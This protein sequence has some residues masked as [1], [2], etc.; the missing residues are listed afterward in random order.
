RLNH[1][2]KRIEHSVKIR[3]RNIRSGIVNKI[4]GIVEKEGIRRVDSSATV[5]PAMMTITTTVASDDNS[6]TPS[7][8]YSGSSQ[9][10]DSPRISQLKASGRARAIG[11]GG[12]G[13]GGGG[14]AG[15]AG[16]GVGGGHGPQTLI[17]IE[18]ILRREDTL[19]DFVP[20]RQAMNS[21]ESDFDWDED[22]NIDDD[23]KNN[24]DNNNNNNNNNSAKE[25]KKKKKRSTWRQLAPFLRML[26]LIITVAPIVALPAVLTGIFLKTD[27]DPQNRDRQNLRRRVTK[28]AVVVI[29]GWLAFMWCII[30]INNWV[31]DLI[32]AAAVMVCSWIAPTK[33]ET[34]K[35]RLLIFVGT[36]KYIKWFID[37][38]WALAAFAVLSNMVYPLV[39]LQVWQALVIRILVSVLVLMG[40]VLLEKIILHKISKNF[41]QIAYADRIQENKY[42]LAVLDRLGTSRRKDKRA[43]GGGGGGGCDSAQSN[44]RSTPVPAFD[45]TEANTSKTP[46]MT[47]PT[48]PCT[49][50][51]MNGWDHVNLDSNGQST[52]DLLDDQ[53]VNGRGAGPPSTLD[54]RDQDRVHPQHNKSLHYAAKAEIMDE[55]SDGNSGDSGGEGGG[56]GDGE[57]PFHQFHRHHTQHLHVPL[58]TMTPHSTTVTQT[59]TSSYSRRKSQ[60]DILKG[61]NRKLHVLARADTNPSKDINSTENAK[62]LARSLFH[63]LQHSPLADQLTPPDFYP[64]F[65]TPEDAQKAFSLFDKDGNGDISKREMKEKIFYVYKERKDLHTAL[66]DL[67]Q[68]HPYDSG[69]L[70]DIDGN[71]MYVREVGLN[72]TMFVTWDGRRI[73]YPNN[74]LSQKAINNIRRS[75]NMTDKIVVHIDVYTSQEKI[76]DLRARMRDFLAK[77]SK[78]F[79]PDMEIQIQEIDVRLKISMCIEHKGNWQDSARRWARRTK[80]HYALKEAIEDLGIKYH[81]IP[82]RISLMQSEGGRDFH[83]LRSGPRRYCRGH[84]GHHDEAFRVSAAALAAARS[85]VRGQVISADSH[86]HHEV[87]ESSEPHKTLRFFNKEA[88]TRTKEIV[89]HV[90]TGFH[91]YIGITSVYPAGDDTKAQAEEERKAIIQKF[92]EELKASAL[93]NEKTRRFVVPIGFQ[94]A[95]SFLKALILKWEFQAVAKVRSYPKPRQANQAAAA[96]TLYM[97]KL[98][99]NRAVSDLDRGFYCALKHGYEIK[100]FIH[101]M[102]QLWLGDFPV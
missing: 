91:G 53:S 83:C 52:A 71:F 68:A 95:D 7:S 51:R 18:N 86:H 23:D 97:R 57:E 8:V 76:F 50:S 49:Q 85:P 37:S 35:S 29:F 38:C 69:D 73:Y 87:G 61:L 92:Q 54:E 26:I 65:S 34:L 75:P 72:S 74:V 44:G 60:R 82:E 15:V 77:E 10:T 27:D 66:R 81:S 14:R 9:G 93:T 67:S 2:S 55:Y 6:N 64:Y 32:P 96:I 59:N 88:F 5:I 62:R 102:L 3:S 39:A 25:K 40:L 36:K 16:S 24:L 48:R 98:V 45:Q 30:C 21:D 19:N 80:F 63:N 31:I 11:G 58:P 43:R 90:N 28:D 13:G 41:H 100:Q 1:N 42:A 33:V 20:P 84:G 70:C 101:M 46:F 12:G 4:D 17:E 89:V 78:E 94:S 22:I 47:D 99:A 79:S 56:K